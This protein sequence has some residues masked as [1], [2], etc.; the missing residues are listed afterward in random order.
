VNLTAAS[1]WRNTDGALFTTYNAYDDAGNFLSTT[2]PAGHTTSFD[3]TDSWASGFSGS[4]GSNA[5]APPNSGQGKAY[6]SKITNALG[7][8]SMQSYYS[9]TGLFGSF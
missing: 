7:Q 5:C 9:C 8:F 3:Y 1:R 2:D 4:T 6:V